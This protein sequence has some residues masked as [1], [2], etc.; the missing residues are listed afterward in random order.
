MSKSKGIKC[1]FC[2][3]K[4]HE[5]DIDIVLISNKYHI[6]CEKC[7]NLIIQMIINE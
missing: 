7:K 4:Y 6:L 3:N 5:K 2:S 1:E